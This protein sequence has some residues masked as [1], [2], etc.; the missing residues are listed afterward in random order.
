MPNARISQSAVNI[1][2]TPS[3]GNP[4]NARIAQS[5]VNL[6]LLPGPPPSVPLQMTLGGG[7]ASEGCGLHHPVYGVV[8]VQQH[9][10]RNLAM[11]QAVLF[12]HGRTRR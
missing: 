9:R 5:V 10:P 3:G 7:C 12:R 8:Q 4:I 1:I 11:K 6:V 2:F